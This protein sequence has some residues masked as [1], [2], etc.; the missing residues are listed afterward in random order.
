MSAE[1]GA[2]NLSDVARYNVLPDVARI[3]GLQTHNNRALWKDRALVE[4]NVAVVHS[5]DKA[6][7]SIVDHHSASETFMF[8]FESETKN[9]GFIPCDWVWLT[10]PISGSTSPIFHQGMIVVIDVICSIYGIVFYVYYSIK[11]RNDQRLY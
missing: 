10:P 9:R 6:H 8:H 11:F 1:I 5:F 4:L 7:V 2:R 3:M